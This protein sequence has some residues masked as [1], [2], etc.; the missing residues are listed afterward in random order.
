[1]E[2][3]ARLC[4][5]W[6]FRYHWL[7]CCKPDYPMGLR[8]DDSI[9]CS[10]RSMT[11]LSAPSLTK[12]YAPGQLKRFCTSDHWLVHVYGVI[13]LHCLC[14]CAL[15]THYSHPRSAVLLNGI[16]R[17]GWDQG[18]RATYA[19]FWILKS[20]GATV[21]HGWPSEQDSW[22]ILIVR[23]PEVSNVTD[24][25]HWFLGTTLSANHNYNRLLC[26]HYLHTGRGDALVDMMDR[27]MSKIPITWWESVNSGLLDAIRHG[28]MGGWWIGHRGR[29]RTSPMKRVAI[30]VRSISDLG[31]DFDRLVYIWH[32]KSTPWSDGWYE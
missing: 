4:Q 23:G 7:I 18:E 31:S 30:Y 2:D 25:N 10:K 29:S 21:L 14:A 16:S 27:C 13:T 19:R 15:W 1:M 17:H 26:A 6:K 32:L 9:Y 3:I 12:A 22:T 24:Y 11:G 28:G 5:F 8:L 20:F